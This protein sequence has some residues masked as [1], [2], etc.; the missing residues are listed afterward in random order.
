M[1]GRANIKKKRKLVQEK[2][3]G[4]LIEMS[5]LPQN[6]FETRLATTEKTNLVWLDK[7]RKTK[8][9]TL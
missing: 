9:P 8:L 4:N 1:N 5:P 2:G 7:Y 6:I 3:V